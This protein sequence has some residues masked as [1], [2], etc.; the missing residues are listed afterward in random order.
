[1]TAAS[2]LLPCS[3]PA[4]TYKNDQQGHRFTQKKQINLQLFLF[5]KGKAYALSAKITVQSI[6]THKTL[7]PGQAMGQSVELILPGGF[8]FLPEERV[9]PKSVL[10]ASLKKVEI[11]ARTGIIHGIGDLNQRIFIEGA[12]RL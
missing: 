1:M 2:I 4:S 3:K 9:P 7:F 5:L 12:L 8:I 11:L 10:F 6:L